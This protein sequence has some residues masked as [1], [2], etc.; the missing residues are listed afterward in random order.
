M[1]LLFIGNESAEQFRAG[2][3]TMTAMAEASDALGIDK[4][5]TDI[6]VLE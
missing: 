5:C 2:L 6:L 3:K 1:F 4:C